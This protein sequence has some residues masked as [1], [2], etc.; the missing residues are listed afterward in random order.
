VPESV[1]EIVWDMECES[2]IEFESVGEV[3]GVLVEVKDTPL[4]VFC[5]LT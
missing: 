4:E 5:P 3:D 2:V 1:G